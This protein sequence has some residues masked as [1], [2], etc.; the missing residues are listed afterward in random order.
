MKSS[1]TSR[2]GKSPEC[3]AAF[4]L[5]EMMTAIAVLSLIMI[6][7]GQVLGTV[8]RAWVDGQRHVN[9]F[10]K[11]RAMLNLFAND[12]Q[13]GLFRNDL[14]AFPADNTG[15]TLI[16]FYTQRQ[17]IIPLGGTP[18][19]IS[20]VQYA[21]NADQST[22]TSMTTLQRGDLSVTW[23]ATA[24]AVTFGNTTDF[25]GNTPIARDTVAGVVN[26]KVMFVYA[27]GTLSETYTANTSNPLRAVGLTLAVV[28][29]RTLKLLKR[30]QIEGLR[31]AFDETLTATALSNTRSVKAIW[32]LYENSSLDWKSYPA[33]LAFGLKIFEFYVNLT[34]F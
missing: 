30:E 5:L 31:N 23:T 9:N 20:L 10:T 6:M 4:T 7:L 25:G 29:D 22:P 13:C 14:C 15:K 1:P 18:R 16:K 21:Y 17:G 8:S 2:S 11:A 32:E 28:D 24:S 34:D 19:T 26:Y 12:I 33:S 3:R 27:D